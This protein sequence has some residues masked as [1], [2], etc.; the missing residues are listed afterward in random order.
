MVLDAI[1]AIAQDGVASSEKQRSD[2][3]YFSWPTQNQVDGYFEQ[4]YRFYGE[5][6]LEDFVARQ[7]ARR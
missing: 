4:G 2:G 7:T 3:Q 1:R 6:E 5:H